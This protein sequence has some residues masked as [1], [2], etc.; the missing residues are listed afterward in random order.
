MDSD[1]PGQGGSSD[2]QAELERKANILAQAALNLVADKLTRDLASTEDVDQLLDARL[3]ELTIQG[4]QG[5]WPNFVLPP[6]PAPPTTYPPSTFTETSVPPYRWSVYA[7]TSG[8]ATTYHCRVGKVWKGTDANSTTIA[9]ATSNLT[10]QVPGAVWLKVAGAD[11]ANITLESGA[12]PTANETYQASGANMT[13]HRKI[14]GDFSDTDPGVAALS[15]GN[16]SGV[17]ETWYRPRVGDYDFI[18]VSSVVEIS[19]N[20]TLAVELQPY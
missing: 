19:G 20:A 13:Y 11:L 14:L 6:A 4:A 2:S 18:A 12:V 1:N 5:Y 10:V 9:N 7:N 15:L 16:V 3:G 17:G 8:N